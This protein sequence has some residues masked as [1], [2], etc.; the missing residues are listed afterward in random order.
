[1]KVSL[2]GRHVQVS[3][4]LTDR[5][6]DRFAKLDRFFAGIQRAEVVLA[7]DGHGPG[8]GKRCLVDATVVLG[9][10][11]RINCAG[12]ADEMEAA[13][14]LAGT[15]MEK[16]IRRFH[17]KLKRRRDRTRISLDSRNRRAEE[18]ET[19]EEIVR[20]MLEEGEE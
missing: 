20:E 16:Q 13:I 19:Y 5:V 14:D 3:P 11:A 15:R 1:M 10:G 9:H 6:E 8:A 4:G 7:L 12:Q 18:E 17:A 2:I